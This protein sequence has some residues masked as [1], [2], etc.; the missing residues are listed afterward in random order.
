MQ[1]KTP[2]ISSDLEPLILS[3][4]SA[5]P[6]DSIIGSRNIVHP[7]HL[8][9]FEN[10]V[11]THSNPV[12][13]SLFTTDFNILSVDPI[14][15]KPIYEAPFLLR[16]STWNNL[17]N[18]GVKEGIEIAHRKDYVKAIKDYYNVALS[19]DREC[20]DA[21]VARGAAYANQHQWK[22]AICDLESALKLDPEH[23]NAKTYLETARKRQAAV[24]NEVESAQRGEYLMDLDSAKPR[25]SAPRASVAPLRMKTTSIPVKFEYLG[26]PVVGSEP[27]VNVLA[28]E[29][30]S[31]ES[32]KRRKK[33][34]KERKKEK[35]EKKKKSKKEKK[36]SKKQK[37]KSETDSESESDD[38]ASDSDNSRNH[39]DRKRKRAM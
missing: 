15:N 27:L 14:S 12:A 17:I 4:F 13:F 11:Y 9:P 39:E 28:L 38:S 8:P 35:R 23:I 1:E 31:E 30:D 22:L 3:L 7:A 16:S 29:E 10:T 5:I 34:K 20:V 24:K 25:S 6:V 33:E 2:N 26:S 21:Y 19:I 37:K 36:R 18:A 32:R